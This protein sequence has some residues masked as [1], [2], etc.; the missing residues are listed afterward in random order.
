MRLLLVGQLALVSSGFGIV[1]SPQG[2]CFSRLGLQLALEL[3]GLPP[4]ARL[5]LL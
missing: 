1:A 4:L 3:V 5:V 2:V